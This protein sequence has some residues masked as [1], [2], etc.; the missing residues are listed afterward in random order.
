MNESPSEIIT[1]VPAAAQRGIVYLAALLLVAAMTLLYFGKVYV[2]VNARGRIVPEGDVALLQ[3]IQGGVVKAV[4]A[5]AGD[6][7]PA[8]APVI[9]LDLSEPGLTLTEVRQKLEG[10][11]EELGRLRATI[12]LIERIL[13]RPEAAL[14][15]TRSTVI[16]TVGKTTELINELENLKARV[17]AAG[18]AVASWPARRTAMVREV[19]L[20]RENVRVNET[21][22]SS[23]ARLLQSTEAALVQ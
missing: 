15:G 8:G 18:G 13:A 7:L 16:A 23:Q 21:S 10:Q 3:T 2:V 14:E 17:D 5:K 4:L 1:P 20:T 12:A 6:R 22:Y 11:T 9:K 19:E